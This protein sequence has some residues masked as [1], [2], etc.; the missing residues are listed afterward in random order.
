MY[1]STKS[2]FNPN[3]QRLITITPTEKKNEVD[4][5]LNKPKSRKK[6]KLT[7][8]KKAKNKYNFSQLKKQLGNDMVIKLLLRLVEGKAGARPVG[9][10]PQQQPTLKKPR[11]MRLARGSGLPG[12]EKPKLEKKKQGE[13]DQQFFR[14]VEE[15]I[16]ENNPSYL[17]FA[18]LLQQDRERAEALI[19]EQIQA[20]RKQPVVVQQAAERQAEVE[21]GFARELV[22]RLRVAEGSSAVDRQK[23]VRQGLKEYTERTG[24]RLVSSDE[25]YFYDL[26]RT[27]GKKKREEG[28]SRVA[29]RFYGTGT[30]RRKARA[31][32]VAEPRTT[33]LGELGGDEP[34]TQAE[35]R[36]QEE[37][38]S[39]ETS[40]GEALSRFQQSG[41]FRRPDNPY[42]RGGSS[43]IPLSPDEEAERLRNPGRPTFAETGRETKAQRKKRLRQEQERAELEAQGFSTTGESEVGTPVRVV[44]TE[45]RQPEPEGSEISSGE[46]PISPDTFQQ[47]VKEQER[48]RRFSLLQQSDTGEVELAQTEPTGKVGSKAVARTGRSPTPQ[49]IQGRQ[50]SLVDTGLSALTNEGN[51]VGEELV[52]GVSQSLIATGRKVRGVIPSRDKAR[53]YELEHGVFGRRGFLDD[54]ITDEQRAASLEFQRKLK[55]RAEG[56]GEFSSEGEEAGRAYDTEGSGAEEIPDYFGIERET[57]PTTQVLDPEALRAAGEETSTAGTS[58]PPDLPIE[59]AGE[60]SGAESGFTTDATTDFSEEE[61]DLSYEKLQQLKPKA[62]KKVFKRLQGQ[63]KLSDFELDETKSQL[64]AFKGLTT[65]QE[66]LEADLQSLP[67]RIR[68]AEKEGRI[69]RAESL[70]QQFKDTQEKY[71]KL[72]FGGGSE[73]DSLLGELQQEF[74]SSSAESSRGTDS[75][76]ESALGDFEGGEIDVSEVGESVAGSSDLA[77]LANT[78]FRGKKQPK[79]KKAVAPVETQSVESGA[80]TEFSGFGEAP[81]VSRVRAEAK[82]IE[83]KTREQQIKDAIKDPVRAYQSREQALSAS[84]E[85]SSQVQLLLKDIDEEGYKKILQPSKEEKDLDRLRQVYTDNLVALN[86]DDRTRQKYLEQEGR[87]LPDKSG[88]SEQQKIQQRKE[89]ERLSKEIDKQLAP[90]EKLRT[91]QRKEL[92]ELAKRLREK[93]RDL[94][95]VEYKEPFSLKANELAQEVNTETWADYEKFMI[96]KLVEEGKLT[97]EESTKLLLTP[98]KMRTDILNKLKGKSQFRREWRMKPNSD[99]VGQGWWLSYIREG[100]KQVE[101][102]E[103]KVKPGRPEDTPEVLDEKAQAF[104]SRLDEYLD[105]FLGGLDEETSKRVRAEYERVKVGRDYDKLT[106]GKGGSGQREKF[107]S[108]LNTRLTRVIESDAKEKDGLSASRKKRDI[109]IERFEPFVANYIGKTLPVS[110]YFKYNKKRNELQYLGDSGVMIQTIKGLGNAKGSVYQVY[111]KETPDRYLLTSNGDGSFKVELVKAEKGKKYVITMD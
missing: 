3:I 81:E 58:L 98:F 60:S 47:R 45:A 91:E 66:Q 108:G 17:Y 51:R 7:R 18:Q 65:E 61:K 62:Q 89:Y 25:E 41:S 96:E 95:G 63:V 88:L 8:T 32:V 44:K 42:D 15:Y 5:K 64:R 87:E 107:F 109:K 76:I 57:Q 30:P 31:R 52:R 80:E 56:T 70:E 22:R 35:K 67:V 102:D 37:F 55:A 1:F 110:D 21:P 29:Q 104:S 27:K 13:T 38:T 68:L 40:A 4:T 77:L 16:S 49:G 73:T 6:G 28:E 26:A 39:G 103:G 20:L 94:E 53:E 12:R 36:L 92:S 111:L 69:G 72:D 23:I 50:K 59:S 85:D 93:Y 99:I 106:K 100:L 46:N 11:S 90:Y 97:Q 9:R 101:R 2:Y 75:L 48:E 43:E 74:Y 24:D 34:F 105:E 33:T 10:P 86:A 79:P 54:I 71:A 83:L 82:L 78:A 84:V 19:R 14:R